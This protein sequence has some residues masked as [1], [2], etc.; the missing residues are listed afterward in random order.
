MK[1]K[2]GVGLLVLGF[3]VFATWKAWTGS[4]NLAPVDVLLPLRAGE[5]VTAQ[6]RPNL[7]GLYLLE[8]TAEPTLPAE[9]LHCLM[10]LDS[11]AS[12]CRDVAPGLAIDWVVSQD[13]REIRRGASAQ[14]QDAAHSAVSDSA[15]TVRVIGEFPL[16]AGREY[17]LQLTTKSDARA[18]A[19]AHPR[20]RVVISSLARTDFQSASVLVFSISFICVLFGVILLVV[21]YFAPR[22]AAKRAV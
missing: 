21:A 1:T 7:D 14:T 8:L 12:T 9:A 4:R 3:G 6:F 15:S 13:G 20:L 2:A 5:T 11:N 19:P 10:S 17:H 16:E 18:L 22:G